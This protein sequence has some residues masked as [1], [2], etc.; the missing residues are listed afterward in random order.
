MAFVA[1]PISASLGLETAFVVWST[2]LS[3]NNAG[4]T[5]TLLRVAAEVI[6][7][8]VRRQMS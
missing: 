6:W 5:I 8:G 7:R 1:S 4:Y 2:Q 3:G